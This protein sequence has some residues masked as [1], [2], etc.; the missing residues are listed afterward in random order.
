MI[1]YTISSLADMLSELGESDVKEML[2][3]FSSPKNRDVEEYLKDPNK[4]I[5]NAKQNISPTSLV[6]ASVDETD[7]RFLCGYFTLTTKT[8]EVK[9]K[10]IDRNTYDKLKKFGAHDGQT[11]TIPAPLIAQL[12]KNYAD[13]CNNLIDGSVLLQMACDEV[14]KAQ[15]IIGGKVVYLE[16]EDTEKLLKFYTDNGFREFSRRELDYDEQDSFTGQY[17]VQMLKYLKD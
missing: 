16:C 2:S 6:Y 13:N 7:E 12:G 5:E 1:E 9:R 8:I 3:S 10:N 4:G 11:C 14:R 17:L 15:Q